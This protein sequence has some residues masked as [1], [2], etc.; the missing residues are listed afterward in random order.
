MKD[1]VDAFAQPSRHGFTGKVD[2]NEGNGFVG[3]ASGAAE[4]MNFM[5]MLQQT[6]DDSSSDES[7]SAGN[8]Y[9][10]VKPSFA[11]YSRARARR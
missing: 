5:S 6:P 10:H 1:G 11:V 4:Y 3:G 8:Q 9:L 2:G 7:S